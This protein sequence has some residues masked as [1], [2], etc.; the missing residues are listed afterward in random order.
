MSWLPRIEIFGA[1]LAERDWDAEGT[2]IQIIWRSFVFEFTFAR[3]D[4]VRGGTDAR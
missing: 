3:I 4:R 1:C 2:Q